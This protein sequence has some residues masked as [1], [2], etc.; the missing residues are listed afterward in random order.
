MTLLAVE[1]IKLFSTR[2]PWWCM[3][4]AVAL[5]VGLT[6][7]FSATARTSD[8]YPDSTQFAYQLGVVVLMV[9]AVLSITTEYRFSTIRATF[10]AVPHRTSALIAKAVVVGGIC[11]LLG[12]ITAVGSWGVAYLISPDSDLTI[13]T[14]QEYRNV[15]GVGLFYLV[16]AVLALAVGL[17][18]RH[19]AGAIVVVLVELFLVENLVPSIP[20]IGTPIQHWLPFAVGNN[21]LS[22]GRPETLDGPPLIEGMPLGA[23]GSLLYFA[24]V[25]FGLLAIAIAVAKRRDA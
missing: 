14:A 11:G 8:I 2:S 19:T 7:I 1:R 22:A 9:M 18:I 15:F 12:E 21:F 6:S 25:A 20:K 5:T 3:A 24:A 4:L 13:N 23:W 17:L 16:A 10:L